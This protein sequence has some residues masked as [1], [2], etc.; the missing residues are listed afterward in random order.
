MNMTSPGSASLFR[1]VFSHL[2]PNEQDPELELKPLISVSLSHP[3]SNMKKSPITL[4]WYITVN[5]DVQ[6]LLIWVE[7]EIIGLKELGP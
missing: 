5:I 4:Q 7:D 6:V 1:S 3:S 2:V